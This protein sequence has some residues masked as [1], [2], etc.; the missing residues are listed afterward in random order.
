[1]AKKTIAS[2]TRAKGA[3][4][5]KAS[6]SAV[7]RKK[8]AKRGSG[9]AATRAGGKKPSRML[10]IHAAKKKQV[11]T[12]K[13]SD[14]DLLRKALVALRERISG[15]MTSL[16]QDSLMRHDSSNSEE[17]GT[18][19]F[20]R[21]LAL[22]LVNNEH[23]RI[24]AIDEALRRID[25]GSYGICESCSRHIEVPRLKA[26]PFVRTCISCQSEKEKAAGRMR[27][28]AAMGGE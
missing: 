23:E 17:D 7:T 27:T 12:L 18:D 25:E 10:I 24:R 26:L 16:R 19:A 1:M 14:K 5:K 13:M 9:A 2:K 8:T 22:G 15:N 3:T 6:R 20:E 21:Q 11:S 28:V 4:A